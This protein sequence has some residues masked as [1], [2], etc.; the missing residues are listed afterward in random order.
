MTNR[1]PKEPID[2]LPIEI[3]DKTTVLQGLGAGGEVL[4][5]IQNLTK[6]IDGAVKVA[7]TRTLPQDWI[8]QGEKFYLQ[9][10]GIQKVRSVFG[11][12]YKDITMSKLSLEDG[13]YAYICAGTVGSRLLNQLYGDTEIWIEGMRNSNDPFFIGKDGNR[14]FDEMDVRKSA[15][16][17]FQVRGATAILGLGNFTERDLAGMGVNVSAIPKIDYQKGAEGGGKPILISDAQRNRLFAICKSKGVGEQSLK[18]YMKIAHK[19]ESTSDIPRG[20]I[21]DSICK[22][23]ETGAIVDVLM[24]ADEKSIDIEKGR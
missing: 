2:A 14:S 9:A 10:T 22:A 23:V 13:G 20:Q 24:D 12:Y 1:D 21:Y 4:A 7:L 17:N 18:K 19:L 6:T 16:A 3:E 15:H 11:I 5:R 8:K